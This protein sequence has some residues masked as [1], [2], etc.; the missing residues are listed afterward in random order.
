MTTQAALACEWRAFGT[1]VQV[2]R[3]IM[4]T[5]DL[6]A[7]ATW[8]LFATA[9]RPHP[10]VAAQAADLTARETGNAGEDQ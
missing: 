2:Y 10:A 9:M 8:A 6:A 5:D 1:W 4:A 3:G 7:G